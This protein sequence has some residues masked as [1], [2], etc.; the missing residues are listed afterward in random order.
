MTKKLKKNQDDHSW[1]SFSELYI[2]IK[3]KMQFTMHSFSDIIFK[4]IF[5]L[6]HIESI[7]TLLLFENVETSHNKESALS[8]QHKQ[9]N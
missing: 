5:N 6:Y 8:N 3:Y 9:L 1:H 7:L 4:Y 2:Y